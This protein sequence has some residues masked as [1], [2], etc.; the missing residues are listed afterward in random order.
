MVSG[1]M[2]GGRKTNILF[3]LWGIYSIS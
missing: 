2:I 3:D 1:S